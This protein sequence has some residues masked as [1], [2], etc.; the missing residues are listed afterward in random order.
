MI[1]LLNIIRKLN[2]RNFKST[3]LIYMHELDRK[4][5]ILKS[6]IKQTGKQKCLV[7]AFVSRVFA[8]GG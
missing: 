4:E 8:K 2:R 6:K 1:L 3:I 5:A 7:F